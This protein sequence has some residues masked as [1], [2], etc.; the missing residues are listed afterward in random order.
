LFALRG[1]GV[2]ALRQG[3]LIRAV[4]L[5][6]RAMAIC[7]DAHH[8]ANFPGMAVDLGEA[9]I[10]SGRVTGAVPL[11]ARAIEQSSMVGDGRA[12]A[13]AYRSMGEARLL[14]GHLEEARAL[15]ERALALTYKHQER[16]YQAYTL[17]LL[18]DIG[19]HRELPAS[20]Q[21]EAHYRQALA[22]AEDLGM[23]PLQAHCHLGLGTLYAQVNRLEQAR[24]E[25]STAIALYRTMDMTFW[26]P[27]AEAA[28]ASVAGS[29][30]LK[31]RSGS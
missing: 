24:A 7:Q 13:N 23:R 19:R 14:S 22:L 4:P 3:D 5:L 9:Y 27:R 26:L 8:V 2:L 31:S 18:G 16:G 20:D 12:E 25:L 1:G 10:L 15:A 30:S 6:E 21:A 17:R 11:L 28:L 29:G